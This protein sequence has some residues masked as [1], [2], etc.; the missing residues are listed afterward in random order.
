MQ[1]TS[2]FGYTLHTKEKV[3]A[4]QFAFTTAEAG[5]F[6]A[7]FSADGDSKGLVVKLNLDWKIGI[8][9]KDWDS[10]AKREK[11]EVKYMEL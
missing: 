7:C 2:P 10:V 3:S 6:L 8:A 4:D 5:N 1:V 9:T 11:L